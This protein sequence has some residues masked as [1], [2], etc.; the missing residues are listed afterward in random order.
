MSTTKT[1]ELA[2][3]ALEAWVAKALGEKPGTAY[4][5]D[6][7]GFDRQLEHEAIQVVP[8]PGTGYQ[9]CAIVV[10]RPGGRPPGEARRFG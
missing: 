9:W 1:S 5:M 4:T 8:M 6:W 7:P 3:A 10:G 2:D